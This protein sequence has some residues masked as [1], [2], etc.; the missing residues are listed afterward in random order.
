MHDE[1]CPAS[2]DSN[3][4]FFHDIF[5][6]WC[7]NRVTRVTPFYQTTLFLSMSMVT[8]VSQSKLAGPGGI[9]QEKQVDRLE[10]LNSRLPTSQD[11]ARLAGV[12]RATVSYVLNAAP[13]ARISETTRQRV[14][15]AAAELGYIPHKFASSLRSGHSDLVLLPFFDWPYN[16]NSINFLRELALQL[17]NLGYSV[18]LRF[19]GSRDRKTL[20]QKIAT[21][22]PIGMI[23]VAGE[24]TKKDIDILSRNGVKAVLAYGAVRAS[25]IPSVSIDF[26]SAGEC[27]GRYLASKGHRHVAVIVPR[28]PRILHLGLQRLEGFRRIAKETGMKVEKVELGYDTRQAAALAASWVNPAR[29]GAV[30]TYNDEYGMLL[31]AALQEAGFHLPADMALVGC[32]DLPLCEMLRPR[33]TSVNLGSGSPA[34]Q[35]AVYFDQMIR[36]QTPTGSP[37]IPLVCNIVVRESA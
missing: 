28:D 4:K 20:A 34:H 1:N 13:G 16:Q 2:D 37:N 18:M 29:P 6:M 36:G 31:M 15:K 17:D 27:A 3:P 24:F 14:E 32:D 5:L 12:S 8:K 9:A 21:F 30:F 26:T 35:V 25:P 10:K 11:V 7:Y 33:L 22:H 23:S 19:F